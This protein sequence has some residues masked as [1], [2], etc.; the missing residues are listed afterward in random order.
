MTLAGAYRDT[1]DER[2]AARAAL[3]VRTWFLDPATRMNPN[4]DYGQGI[5]GRNTGRGAGIISTRNLVGIV[6]AA[7]SLESSPN[8]SARDREG[9]RQWS[10]AF[11]AWLQTSQNGREE[12]AARNNHGTWYEAQLGALLLYT[13]QRDLARARF[14]KAKERIASQIEPDGSQ[15]RELERTRSWSY[16]VM[17][18]EGWFHVSRLAKEAGVDL[19]NF[20]TSDGRSVRA[21]LD[22]LMPFASGAARWPGAQI[23]PFEVT[24]FLPLLDQAAKAWNDE[25][26]KALADHLRQK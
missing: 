1:H 7:R 24:A 3:L 21:A 11:A 17:N 10:A 26:Y 14:E 15:P 13:G 2:Y 5:P 19:W 12:S 25:R 9:L 22:Y 18:L 4:L 6:E 16:S 20:R 23:T 8:W